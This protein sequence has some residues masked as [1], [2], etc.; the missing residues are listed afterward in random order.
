[1][2]AGRPPLETDVKQAEI[3]GKFKATYKTIA[4]Y[5]GCSVR[6]IERLMSVDD[7]D[8]SKTSEFCRSY[9]KGLARSKLTLSEAQWKNAVEHNNATLQVWLGKNFLDQTDKQEINQ[10]SEVNVNNGYDLSK[11]TPEQISQ[12]KNILSDIPQVEDD[13][14]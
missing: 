1:M 2:P 5:Y 3:F 10:T 8:D 14:A 7:E 13:K 6:T 9:K 12:L 11:A 4:E